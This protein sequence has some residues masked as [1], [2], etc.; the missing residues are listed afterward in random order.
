MP[1]SE[2]LEKYQQPVPASFKVIGI[3]SG[4]TDI[5][6]NVKSFGY[7]CVGCI[8]AETPSDSIPMNDDKMVIIV[9]LDNE[10]VANAI[11]KTYH[12]AGV[13]TIGLVNHADI[14][15][16]DSIV[17]DIGNV[18]F[19]MIIQSLLLPLISLGYIHFTFIDMYLTL[20]NSR[21]FKIFV[22]EGNGVEEAVVN[23]QNR[24]MNIDI[25]NTGAITG[26]LYFNPERSP[27]VTMADMR[28]LS[29]IFSNLLESINVIWSVNYDDSLPE[30]LIKF[31]II[32][33]GEKL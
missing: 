25:R 11:A 14:S 8:L 9:A 20:H 26:V 18:D 1:D 15:C 10:V 5:I 32:M 17:A 6:E 30:D 12:D 22:S 23:M 7:E 4:M 28:H 2:I 3:G 29:N 13:L 27:H 21:T 31:T 33:S 24:M 19:T 16:Y